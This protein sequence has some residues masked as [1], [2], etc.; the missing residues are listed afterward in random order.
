MH[1]IPMS[2]KTIVGIMDA[3]PKKFSPIK[4]LL[5]VGAHSLTSPLTWFEVPRPMRPTITVT[6]T[7]E[8]PTAMVP[9]STMITECER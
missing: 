8:P 9:G 3:E 1:T 2:E 7:K 5:S 4:D 6:S